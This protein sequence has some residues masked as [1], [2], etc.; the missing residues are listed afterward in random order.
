MKTKHL[1]RTGKAFFAI[2][3]AVLF[4]M[5]WS[6]AKAQ[7]VVVLDLPSP[8]SNIGVNEH[9]V[10]VPKISFEIVPNPVEDYALFTV[11]TQDD[12]LGKITIELS[13]MRGRGV[14]KMDFYSAHNTLQSRFETHTLEAGVYIVTLR[15][16]A[17]V[18]NKK[19]IKR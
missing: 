5:T 11:E 1:Q 12:A 14:C 15:C 17:G 2:I 3:A 10:S 19:M 7:T 8:C 6:E 16:E 4:C 9:V 18:L 13:D